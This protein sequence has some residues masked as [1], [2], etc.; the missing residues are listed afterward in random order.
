MVEK[1]TK[2][3]LVTGSARRVGAQTVRSLHAAGYNVIVHY[4]SSAEDAEKLVAEL[5]TTRSDSARMARADLIEIESLPLLIEEVISFWG[6]LDVLVNN[7]SA[8]Y[9]TEV[10]SITEKDWDI[11][12]G[13]N[14]KGPMFL[15]Q[16][17]AKELKRTQG[18]IVNMVD[19]YADRPLKNYLVYSVAKS[20]LVALTKSLARELG[21]EVRANGVAPGAILWPEQEDQSDNNL[22][23]IDQ[24]ALKRK[25]EPM[26]IARTILFLVTD[27]PYI[28][29]QIIAVDGGRTLSN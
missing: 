14:L 5:N 4:R 10:G 9:P 7:A 21:P 17:A 6:R 3:A 22:R 11:L 25:G 20:G 8:F 2:V 23:I 1:T 18:C 15:S 26:D 13:S 29:G 28:T 19:I 27:A 16:A 24:T 12:V